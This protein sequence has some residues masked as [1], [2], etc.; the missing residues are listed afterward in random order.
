MTTLEIVLLTLLAVL[1]IPVWG[2]VVLVLIVAAAGVL[3]LPFV[4]CAGLIA[5]FR[6]KRGK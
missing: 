6:K 5:R 1:T 3:A 2:P 4:A